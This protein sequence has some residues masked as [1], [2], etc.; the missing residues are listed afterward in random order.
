MFFTVW[1]IGGI[2]FVLLYTIYVLF[3]YLKWGMN[4]YRA[5][6]WAKLLYD[7][8]SYTDFGNVIINF[9]C[10]LLVALCFPLVLVTY[11]PAFILLKVYNRIEL[12][13]KCK[14]DRLSRTNET[15]E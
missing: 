12:T 9:V 8:S 11:V 13:N 1:L 5:P 6:K 3:L 4:T 15:E 2:A 10:S 7:D 14:R